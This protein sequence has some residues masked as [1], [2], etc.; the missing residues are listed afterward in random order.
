LMNVLWKILCSEFLLLVAVGFSQ[1][2]LAVK[3]AALTFTADDTGDFVASSLCSE[4]G[5][6]CILSVTS[7]TGSTLAFSASSSASWLFIPFPTGTTPA[8]VAV[9]YK[10]RPMNVGT[11]SMTITLTSPQATNSPLLIPVTLTVVH[12]TLAIFPASLNFS[13]PVSGTSTPPQ[14][15]A[16]KS[17]F[18]QESSF[19]TSVV[20]GNSWLS[21][22][23]LYGTTPATLTVNV[24]P[25]SLVVGT[26]YGSISTINT[27]V[28]CSPI[29]V[30]VTLTIQPPTITAIVNAASFLNQAISPGEVVSIFGTAIGPPSALQL[31]LDSAGK[32]STSLGNVQVLFSGQLSPLTYV[33]ATQVNCIVPYEI[34]GISNPSV[35]VNYSGQA[36]NAIALLSAPTSPGVFATNGAGQAAIL[37]QDGS[38][39]GPSHPEAPGNIVSIFMTGEGQTSPP[40]VTGSVTCQSGCNTLQQIPVPQQAVTAM[41][42]NQPATVTFY[43]EA[44]GLVAGVLQVNL[45]IPAN[46]PPGATPLEISVGGTKSQTGVTLSVR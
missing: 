18:P 20:T 1:E 17:I 12:Q 36:S 14:S 24:N 10:L 9:I 22:S 28:C 42:G 6:R 32:V 11:Y 15:I 33:S 4:L 39:N 25:T 35:Q 44:P 43:G 3:P 23:P 16:L 29:V 40:G 13:A 41:V 5:G 8:T 30:P 31:Q 2:L 21:V 34:V 7:I 27:Q 46:T 38:V 37:N 45:I 26:Y 19:I